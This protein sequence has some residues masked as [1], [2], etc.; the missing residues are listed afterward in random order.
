MFYYVQYNVNYESLFLCVSVSFILHVKNER[1]M[2]NLVLCGYI[3]RLLFFKF[4]ASKH[5]NY[6]RW[7]ISFS[8]LFLFS[9]LYGPSQ[10]KV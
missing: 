5:G 1:S 8:F 4:P 3:S 6:K 9:F 7:L 10:V 2:F